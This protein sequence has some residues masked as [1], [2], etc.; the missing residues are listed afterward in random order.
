M[1]T[2]IEKELETTTTTFDS[3]VGGFRVNESVRIDKPILEY[4]PKDEHMEILG[5]KIDGTYESFEAF[6]K[7][8]KDLQDLKENSIPKSKIREK[9][10]ALDD[11]NSKFYKRVADHTEYT[12]SELVC[13]ILKELL[14]E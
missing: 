1:G 10:V 6:A 8:I 11:S 13:N 7:Y 2:D 14:G 9:I 4:F 5:Q 3:I 12:L